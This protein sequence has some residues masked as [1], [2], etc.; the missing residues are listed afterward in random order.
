[1]L[2]AKS[3]RQP[4]A[5]ADV[6]AR[7]LIRSDR[8]ATAS[9]ARGLTTRLVLFGRR[10]RGLTTQLVLIGR[11]AR[12]P[13]NATCI[14]EPLWPGRFRLLQSRGCWEGNRASGNNNYRE[15]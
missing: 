11:R 13:R 2:S 7:V 5:A 10:A 1:M 6:I 4:K 15:H 14:R 12:G 8:T 9:R 3:R